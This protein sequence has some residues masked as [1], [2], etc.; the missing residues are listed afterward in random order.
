MLEQNVKNK[1]LNTLQNNSEENV[2]LYLSFVE[3]NTG[4]CIVGILI[5]NKNFVLSRELHCNKLQK[6]DTH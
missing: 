5:L 6:N 2:C 3:L 1:G 4:R